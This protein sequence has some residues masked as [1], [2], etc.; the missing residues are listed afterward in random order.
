MH[1]FRISK[2]YIT[3]SKV[4]LH[5]AQNIESDILGLDLNNDFLDELKIVFDD[6]TL[7]NT[8]SVALR[9]S[10]SAEDRDNAKFSRYIFINFKY[11]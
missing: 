9:S 5:K 8:N 11:F 1:I 3:K 6:I 4:S 10:S 7:N 2:I